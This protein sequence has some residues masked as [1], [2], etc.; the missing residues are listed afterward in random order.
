MNP[1]TGITLLEMSV[2]TDAP[3]KTQDFRLT[4]L[5]DSGIVMVDRRSFGDSFEQDRSW[6]ES[7][8]TIS[9]I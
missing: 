7:G 6:D 8:A 4:K 5:A 9:G 3:P 2:M 1:A